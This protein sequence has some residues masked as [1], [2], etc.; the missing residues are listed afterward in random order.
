MKSQKI[1]ILG[2]GNI[3]MGDEGI[4]VHAVRAFEQ[5]YI[6]PEGVEV[7]DGGVA[8]LDL[9]PFIEGRDKVLMVDAVNSGREP[10]YIVILENEGI[11]ARLSAK[12]SMHHFALMDVLSIVRLMDSFPQEICLIGVQPKTVEM[13]LDMSAEMCEKMESILHH[14]ANKLSAWD[15]PCVL[16]SPL[17]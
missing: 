14:I 2:L 1:T 12:D 6:L 10:G 9:I 5:R 13:G 11:P 17:R 8:G 15:V 3:L 16:R 4:G 7:V